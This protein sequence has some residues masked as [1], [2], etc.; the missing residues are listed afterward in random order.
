MKVSVWLAIIALLAGAAAGF[1]WRTELTGRAVE[2]AD[3]ALAEADSFELLFLE[4]DSVRREQLEKI[5]LGIR[6]A[7]RLDTV[8]LTAR[9]QPARIRGLLDS[10]ATAHDSI[11]VL[12]ELD[13]AN[14]AALVAADSLRQSQAL[15]LAALLGRVE[16][17]SV[18]LERRRQRVDSLTVT[19]RDLRQHAYQ[20]P[21]L[22]RKVA[23]V[24]GAVLLWEV[25]VE[26]RVA[27]G[28]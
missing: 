17:D 18:E 2:R 26:P 7:E 14:T 24:A 16:Q 6:E 19:L 27:S 20:P 11:D 21:P 3:K 1:W 5:R 25:V 15:A 4:A 12:L 22:W 23:T 9:E 10:V 8:Y 13:R 28:P